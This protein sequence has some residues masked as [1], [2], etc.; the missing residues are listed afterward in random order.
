MK[1]IFYLLF[2]C[3]T[4]VYANNIFMEKQQNSIY[5]DV[6]LETFYSPFYVIMAPGFSLNGRLNLEY[7][8]G[9]SYTEMYYYRYR[10]LIT[11]GT[12]IDYMLLKKKDDRLP[13]SLSI[14]MKYDLGAY[15]W[16]GTSYETPFYSNDLG[17]GI[18]LYYY[19]KKIKDLRL[20]PGIAVQFG[21]FTQ[22]FPPDVNFSGPPNYYYLDYPLKIYFQVKK[23]YIHANYCIETRYSAFDHTFRLAFATINAGIGFLITP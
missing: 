21:K 9:T 19:P 18:C 22:D 1:R 16:S 13:L 20:I 4:L 11:H 12:E 17:G 8:Y 14:N 7:H 23:F 6:S 2:A 5:L 3:I 10:S 15:L